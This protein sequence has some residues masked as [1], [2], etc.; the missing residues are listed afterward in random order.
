[1]TL[2]LLGSQV[3]SPSSLALHGSTFWDNALFACCLIQVSQW[4]VSWYK[5]YSISYCNMR[6]RYIDTAYSSYA[7]FCRWTNKS[8][9]FEWIHIYCNRNDFLLL[10]KS[11]N[12]FS[13]VEWKRFA[14]TCSSLAR[15]PSGKN[16]FSL[17][18]MIAYISSLYNYRFVLTLLCWIWIL[19]ETLLLFIHCVLT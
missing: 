1:M 14:K 15:Y 16:T 10:K 17:F 12:K 7:Q 8:S 9:F 19:S 2:A 13:S 4:F 5:R 18:A 11:V 6:N 3:D